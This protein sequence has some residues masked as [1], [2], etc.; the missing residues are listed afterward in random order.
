MGEAEK[1]GRRQ[2]CDGIDGAAGGRIK[3]RMRNENERGICVYEWL[4]EGRRRGR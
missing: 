4:C 1:E 2:K 3:R